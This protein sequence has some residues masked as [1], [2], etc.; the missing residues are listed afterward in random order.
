MEDYIKGDMGYIG[1][2]EYYPGG[3]PYHSNFYSHV[4]DERPRLQTLP[5]AG[6]ARDPSQA[7]TEIEKW[8]AEEK[9]VQ[10][11]SQEPVQVELRL[12]NYPA[13]GVEVNGKIETPERPTS[14]N[15]IIVRVPAGKSEIRVSSRTR[16][17]ASLVVVY[18]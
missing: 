4:P 11:T 14:F 18:P 16:W 1:A 3:E 17:I 2:P 6:L 5:P 7:K 15:Q 8:T 12:L 10:V 13:W 9:D